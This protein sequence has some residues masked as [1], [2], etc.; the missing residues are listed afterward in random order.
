MKKL[1]TT[2]LSLMIS[3]QALAC[4]AD[5]YLLPD[6]D[7]RIPV[8]HKG[9]VSGV[10]EAT[11]NRVLASV[12]EVYA[13]LVRA[14]GGRLRLVP[15]WENGQANARAHRL[16]PGAWTVEI[17]GGVARHPA[18]TADGLALVVCHELGHHI[19][20]AP[21][22]PAQLGEDMV[23]ASNEGQ[24]DYFATLKCLR[25]LF[26]SRRNADFVRAT[27][28]PTALTAACRSAHVS[29]AARNLCV[30]TAMAGQ[31]VANFFYAA[32][33][34]RGPAPAF[35]TPSNFAAAITFNGHPA[36]Q[37]RLDTYLQG[38]LCTAK[39]DDDVKQDDVLEGTCNAPSTR[40]VRPACWYRASR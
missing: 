26:D 36:A 19:G 20:G 6:N 8:N 12:N 3:T 39:L 15:L 14:E 17:F 18:M 22:R 13:P 16:V 9:A 1:V 23:W 5:G 30:R 11:F 35:D 10:D 4:T 2:A 28:V 25:R 7:I 24:S 37:C 33:R 34:T 38:A 31:A 21:K 27:T 32:G 40:G 29:A